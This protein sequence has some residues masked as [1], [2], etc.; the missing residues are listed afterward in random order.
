MPD[1]P[2]IAESYLG[3]H[4]VSWTGL[5]GPASLPKDIVDRLAAE[6]VRAVHDPKF[7]EQLLINGVDQGSSP[8]FV[9]GIYR[10]SCR[11]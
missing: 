3:F 1:V 9:P 8:R 10:P 5:M 7:A 4:A 6:M 11:K 2:A